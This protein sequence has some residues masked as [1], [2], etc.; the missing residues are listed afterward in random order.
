MRRHDPVDIVTIGGGMSASILAS[1]I[2]PPTSLRMVSLEQGP[3]QWTYPDFAHNHDSLRFRN[4]YAM[5]QDLSQTTW[6]WRPDAR[7]PALPYRQFGSFHPGEGLG[8]SM[9]HWTAVMWRF[10]PDDFRYRSLNEERYGADRIPDEMTT[11]DWPIGY[12][13]LEPYY[14]QLE[15]DM[16][17]SGRAGNL[18]GQI[19]AGGNPFEGHRRRPYPNPPLAR[20]KFGRLFAGACEGLD[21]HPFPTPAGILSQGYTD[22]YGNTRAGCLY[23]GFCTRY[24]CEVG[25]KTSPLTTWLPP[26]LDTGRYDVRTGCRVLRIE[27]ADDGRATGVR[28]VDSAGEEHV[29]PAEV[30]VCSAFTLENVRMLLLSRGDAHPDGIGNDRGQVGRNYTYQIIQSP[31]KGLWEDETFNFYMGN[32]CTNAQIYDYNADNF[33]HSDLDFL[34][35]AA[36]SGQAG[37]REPISSSMSLLSGFTDRQWGAEWKSMLGRSWDRVGSVN[38]QGDSPAYAGNFL[39]LDPTYKDAWG[40]PMLRITFDWRENER[41]MYRFL[42]ARCEEVLRAMNPDRVTVS[43]ELGSYRIDQYQST[44]PTGGAIMGRDPGE[45]VTNSYGQVWDTP[46]V[47]VTGAALY[48][49]NPGAN[50]SGTVGA[51][52]LRTA[53]AIR[54]RYFSAPGE[55]L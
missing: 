45:S 46:N 30:V 34:G 14:D 11:Q 42:A 41:N 40:V 3:A 36:I 33:D 7:S 13:E 17:V 52:A 51:L 32:G 28:Y 19:L 26:A 9:V 1:Q 43:P 27:T 5:M 54:D 21:L 2:L 25:A 49:Q 12:E 37:Q 47:F 35:G 18:G 44:H 55:L 48:P 16:G 50:P 31:A 8:G 23:C 15:Y 6:T 39:D 4:R 24:G 29:Q 10:L 22:P 20:S 38:I 53:E